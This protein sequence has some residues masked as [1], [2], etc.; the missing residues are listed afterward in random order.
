VRG[1]R[2]REP[3]KPVKN[4]LEIIDQGF[5]K[6]GHAFVFEKSVLYGNLS[7]LMTMM[8]GKRS[9]LKFK[10]PLLGVV[11]GVIPSHPTRILYER[12]EDT[13]A[14]KKRKR[15]RKLRKKLG[16]TRLEARSLQELDKWIL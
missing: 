13:P 14:F 12:L 16:V 7:D 9:R 2:K 5:A 10:G 3:V 8:S 15:V 4:I 6:V 11:K 1:L